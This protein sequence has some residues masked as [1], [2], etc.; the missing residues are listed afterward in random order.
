[1][2]KAIENK[3]DFILLHDV[4][5]GNPN[6]DPDA[7]NMPRID[8]ETNHGII[9]D[10]CTKSK[11]RNYVNTVKQNA[12]GFKIYIQPNVPLER[13]DRSAFNYLSIEEKKI[14]DLKKSDDEFE[15]KILNFMCENFYDVRT[16]GA[17]MTTFTKNKLCGN[18]T[19]PVQIGFGRS[20]DPVFPQEITIT[21]K[22]ITTEKDATQK[23]TEIG[24]KY[25]IPYGL[26]RT[27]GYVSANLA[28]YAQKKTG[29]NEEDLELFWEALMNMYEH[30]HAA[31]RGNMAVRKLI[32]FK[33]KNALGNA[34]AWKLFDAV[35][36]VR[37]DPN[38]PAR[39]FDDYEI[40]ID[41]S[42]IPEGV[43]CI[44]K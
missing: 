1:M 26:Y 18:I 34:P 36:V 14:P 22:T 24:K 5:M 8:I 15:K 43:E 19:G 32:I 9:T 27:E 7:A 30:D 17:V 39:D 13:S 31:M 16:F 10:V 44:I 2:S 42:Q 40:T 11:I 12:N 38:Q 28:T 4:K 41:Y 25:I 37:K 6:G 20:I 35:K 3:Y 21:R 33:H 23:N 29:F